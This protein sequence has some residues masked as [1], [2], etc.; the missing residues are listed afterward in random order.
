LTPAYTDFTPALH[1][2]KALPG[3]K[4]VDACPQPHVT[5]AYT[6]YCREPFPPLP[7]PPSSNAAAAAAADSAAGPPEVPARREGRPVARELQALLQLWRF[8]QPPF[9]AD[10]AVGVDVSETLL[11]ITPQ[12]P[13]ASPGVV[14]VPR[15]SKAPA[16]GGWGE[17]GREARAEAPSSEK[18]RE[19]ADGSEGVGGREW[20]GKRKCVR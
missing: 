11:E 16:P 4:G 12:G 5:R 9:P 18:R 10:S 6:Y 15:P 1:L 20:E 13:S 14:F 7:P 3:M 17:G 8:H 2:G 19:G